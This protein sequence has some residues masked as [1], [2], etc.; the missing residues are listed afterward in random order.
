M[1][2][3]TGWNE[4]VNGSLVEASYKVYNAAW[5]GHILL[6]VWV[7]LSASLFMKT[8]NPTLTFSAGLISFLVFY[9]FLSTLAVSIIVLVLILEL[10]G[11]LYSI[12]WK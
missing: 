5:G 8:K 3:V 11:T 10:S 6:A 9:Q 12:F 4:F 1:T 2:N 7:V